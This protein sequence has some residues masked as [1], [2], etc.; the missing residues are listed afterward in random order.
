MGEAP[1]NEYL[2]TLIGDRSSDSFG[3]YMPVAGLAG[4]LAREAPSLQLR[5]ALAQA[6]EVPIAGISLVYEG[7]NLEDDLTLKENGILEPGPMAKKRGAGRIRIQF[8]LAAGVQLGKAKRDR[9]Q[10][11]EAAQQAASE[12]LAADQKRREEER[13]AKAEADEKIRKTAAEEAKAMADAQTAE[14]DRLVLRCR[15]LDA[16]VDDSHEMRTSL[17]TPVREFA[18]QICQDQGMRTDQQHAEL[19]LVCGGNVLAAGMSLRDAGVKTGDEI[20]YF[21]G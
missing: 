7:K 10:A 14:Q 13:A 1:F 3:G 11:E 12:R 15:L 17:R 21:W 16:A 8:M 6:L 9:E 20:V 19:I 2:A 5:E 18:F 4:K